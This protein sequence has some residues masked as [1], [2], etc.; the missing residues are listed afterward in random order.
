M[1]GF[2]AYNVNAVAINSAGYIF[3]G[4]ADGVYRLTNDDDSWID[5]RGG[6]IS[7]G[8]NVLGTAGAA[9]FA[10]RDR[11]PPQTF[12]NLS[13]GQHDH[14]VPEIGSVRTGCFAGHCNRNKSV[15]PPAYRRSTG[16][17]V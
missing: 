5:I 9:C 15:T 11:Q 7:P 3:A 6:V 13:L 17:A 16:G 14:L 1:S 8:V 12:R 2:T 4:A 10:A